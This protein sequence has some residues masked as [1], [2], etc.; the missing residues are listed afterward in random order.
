MSWIFIA[1]MGLLAF[2]LH[3]VFAGPMPSVTLTGSMEQPVF[4]EGQPVVLAFTL[5]SNGKDRLI[6]GERAS[7]ASSF[8]ITITDKAGHLVPRTALGERILMPPP[9]WGVEFNMRPRSGADA[10]VSLQPRAAIRFISIGNLHYQ[11]QPP[12]AP[13]N[14]ASRNKCSVTAGLKAHSGDGSSGH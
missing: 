10:I 4:R 7:E 8:Q 13:A 12:P 9:A 1:L 3:C 2:F 5:H 6:I 14:L 11:C